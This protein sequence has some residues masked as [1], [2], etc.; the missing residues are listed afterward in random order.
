MRPF[1]VPCGAGLKEISMDWTR[2][3]YVASIVAVVVYSAYPLFF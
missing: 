1:P 3:F 2:F